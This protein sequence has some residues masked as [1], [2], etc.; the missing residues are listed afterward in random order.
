[1]TTTAIKSC[2]EPVDIGTAVC[3]NTAILSFSDSLTHGY[4]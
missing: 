2:L 1:M 3:N 4:T